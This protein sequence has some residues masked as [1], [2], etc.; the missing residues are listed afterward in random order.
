MAV[1]PNDFLLNT[2]YEMD[3]IVYVQEGLAMPGTSLVDGYYVNRVS[4]TH[5][6]PFYPLVFGFCSYDKD[7][8]KTMALPFYDTPRM[9]RNGSTTTQVYNARAL[10]Y[11]DGGLVT[12]YYAIK[13]GAESKPLYYRLYGFEPTTSN[14]KV[15]PTKKYAKIFTLNTDDNY[16]KLYKKG[17]ARATETVTIRHN[18][19]YVPQIQLWLDTGDGYIIGDAYGWLSNITITKNSFSF[20]VPTSNGGKYVAHYRIYYDEA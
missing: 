5:G 18:F 16:R 4:K 8:S 9:E 10:V 19:G 7:F 11:T 20:T 6:L 17:S 13:Q 14:A 12:V 3:K 15:S 1:N 2:D